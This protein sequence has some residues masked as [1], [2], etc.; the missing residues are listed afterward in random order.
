[1]KFSIFNFQFSNKKGF[2]LIEL[3]IVISIIGILSA[4]LMVN[5]I[6]VRQRARDA[7][8]KTDIRQ[9]QAALEMYRADEGSY[10]V[11]IPNCEGSIS[12]KS[13]DCSSTVY[14]QDVPVDPMGLTYYNGGDFCLDSDGSTYYVI[15]CLENKNDSQGVD[16]IADSDTC[17]AKA[18]ACSSGIYYLVK[19]P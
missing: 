18:P 5:F 14:M 15:A 4:L 16:S 19:N 3:L 12:L 9:I 1:M 17:N 2:T 11:D 8:R 10:P 7:Q 13:S 6:G